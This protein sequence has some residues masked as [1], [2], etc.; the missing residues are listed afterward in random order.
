[1]LKGIF[2]WKIALDPS[3]NLILEQSQLM[4]QM[5]QLLQEGFNH[6]IMH[7]RLDDALFEF[8]ELLVPDFLSVCRGPPFAETVLGGSVSTPAS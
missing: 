7:V 6:N 2:S 5:S 8:A 4:H 3:E 1:M